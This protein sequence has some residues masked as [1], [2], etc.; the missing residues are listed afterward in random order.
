[1]L[2]CFVTRKEKMEQHLSRCS[3]EYYRVSATMAEMQLLTF[4][5]LEKVMAFSNMF[6]LPDFTNSSSLTNL[7]I[8]RFDISIDDKKFVYYCCLCDRVSA[9]TIPTYSK[10]WVLTSVFSHLK[11]FKF[12]TTGNLPVFTSP[13]WGQLLPEAFQFQKPNSCFCMWN[14]EKFCYVT[15]RGQTYPW[16]LNNS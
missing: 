12:A 7:T 1:M 13:V 11:S 5:N 9:N 4:N 15:N 3:L 6:D 14:A 10:F 2:L 8:F 16:P